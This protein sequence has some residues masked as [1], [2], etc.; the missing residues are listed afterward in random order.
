MDESANSPTPA[1]SV[2]PPAP[3]APASVRPGPKPAGPVRPVRKSSVTDG[4]FKP[5][6][7]SLARPALGAKPKPPVSREQALALA[8]EKLRAKKRET[9]QKAL[10]VGA[11][12]VLAILVPAAL[13][14]GVDLGGLFYAPP[15]PQPT[16]VI[17]AGDEVTIH[18][19]GYDENG[20]I[21]WPEGPQSATIG[22]GGFVPGLDRGLIGLS[23]GA[24]FNLTLGP[25]DAFGNVSKARTTTVK[26]NVTL[27]R[28]YTMEIGNFDDRW[29][30]PTMGQVVPTNPWQSTVV[31]IGTK[32]VTLRYDPTAGVSLHYYKYWNST[33]TGFNQT[34]I[35]LQNDL[36]VGFHYTRYVAS[37]GM[38]L[39]YM[40]TRSTG[41]SWFLDG[42]PPLAGKTV[43]FQGT[44]V[45][46]R[47][48]AGALRATGSAVA[49]G[50]STCERCHNA[51]GFVA[52]DA[53]ASAARVGATIEVNVTV[54]DPWL[55][56]LL[57]STVLGDEVV[58]GRVLGKA[59]Y[60]LGDI[61]SSGTADARLSLP[62]PTGNASVG[63]TVNAT[64][65]HQ[66]VSGGKPNDL[67]YQLAF[68]VE[69]G[70]PPRVAVA[71]GGQPPR[72][73]GWLLIGQLLGAAALGVMA[74]PV[75]MGL[76][77]H[78]ALRPK[79]KWPRWPWVTTHF[80]LSLVVVAIASVHGT[81]L[82]STKYRGLW[83]PEI[84]GGLIA[85]AGIGVLG[86]TGIVMAKWTSLKWKP[87]RKVHSYVMLGVFAAM[88][89]HVLVAG[90]TI[91]AWL[92]LLG[93]P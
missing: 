46:V 36:F 35:Y 1:A 57:G 66:H 39:T 12:S 28:N 86:I 59:T 88:V 9:R 6:A 90:T 78:A 32:F 40:V 62:A 31:S 43:H 58:A 84:I 7:A 75:G 27:S 72:T 71:A 2:A 25:Q 17:A 93:A 52:I 50:T 55:H 41:S 87:M 56:D 3:E 53:S 76:K 49:V 21:F 33:V 67:P 81:L 13:L 69:V 65:H 20:S 19:L 60:A 83:T 91:R 15:P 24:S 38:N 44:V 37:A 18:V 63:V 89:I 77:R 51:D 11:M 68:S 45:S 92:G 4:P 42:N 29:P 5:Q 82:M 16:L 47:P 22:G 8:Q 73:S 64:A 54:D 30:G 80:A 79:L 74:Y 48:G 34:Q 61:L 85:L 23:E 70:G 10:L 14:A 26:M